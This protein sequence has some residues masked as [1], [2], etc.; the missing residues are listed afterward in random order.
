M[1]TFHVMKTLLKE[2]VVNKELFVIGFLCI[3]IQLYFSWEAV[4][5]HFQF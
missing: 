4:A 2:I 1:K 3:G 5:K